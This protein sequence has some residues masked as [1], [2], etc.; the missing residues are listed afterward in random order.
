M[1]KYSEN[2]GKTKQ[3]ADISIERRN[4]NLCI[5]LVIHNKNTQNEGGN[6]KEEN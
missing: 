6:G 3:Q 2:A 5:F 1:W 4:T